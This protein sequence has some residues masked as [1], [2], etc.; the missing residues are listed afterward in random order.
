MQ[1]RDIMTEKPECC[2][3]ES[4]LQEVAQ[5]MADHDCGEIPVMEKNRLVGVV[6]DRDIACRA[7]AKGKTPI[8]TKV[9][10]IMSNP[11]IIVGID[12]DIDECCR[13]METAQVRRLPV[14][15]DRGNCCGIVSQ[16]DIARRASQQ[17]AGEVVREVSEPTSTSGR[18]REVASA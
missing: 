9:R 18:A 14:V 3:P 10:E 13:L 16:A 7:V 2:E 6:T 15:D 12:T 11:V 5:M 8:D 1:V 17:K 4:T